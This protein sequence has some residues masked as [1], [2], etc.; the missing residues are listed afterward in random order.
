MSKKVVLPMIMILS[1]S[2]MFAQSSNKIRVFTK[3]YQNFPV[4]GLVLAQPDKNGGVKS[5]MPVGS[6]RI[7]A[8]F[9]KGIV[10]LDGGRAE[11]FRDS[12]IREKIR[13]KIYWLDAEYFPGGVGIGSISQ[14][15]FFFNEGDSLDK[16]I[17]ECSN[18]W[19]F[20]RLRI[21]PEGISEKWLV[22]RL[23]FVTA[24]RIDK[25]S[26]PKKI[27]LDRVFPF[28]YSRILLIGFPENIDCSPNCGIV[29]WLAILV[30][31][32]DP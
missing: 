17:Y 19:A 12:L 5:T 29:Y 6:S 24:L 28:D 3:I 22:L 26:G 8:A 14:H 23:Q 25:G 30:E 2:T 27:L 9:P 11:E 13:N 7:T 18:S 20:F 16:S 31:I 4:V 32:S 10:L 15:E 21:A 1:T